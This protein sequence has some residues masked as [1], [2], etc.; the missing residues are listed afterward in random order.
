MGLGN[1]WKAICGATNEGIEAVEDT[2]SMRILD[3]DMR[4]AD[5]AISES[6]IALTKIMAQR[7]MAETKVAGVEKEVETYTNHALGAAEKGDESLAEE[8]A[9][10]VDELESTLATEKAILEGFKKSE[11]T[12]KKRIKDATA[13]IKRTKQTIAQVKATA[14]VQKAQAAVSSTNTGAGSSVNTALSSLE[15]IKKQQEEKAAQF[16]A[17]EELANEGTDAGL[18]ERL[19]KAGVSPGGQM[20]GKSKLAELMA[21]KAA[22]EAAAAE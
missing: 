19:K 6:N 17:A 15:K 12:L 22:A 11:V 7:K 16:E 20:G 14:S 13:T 4:T 21:K 5:K 18:E 10:K 9:E 1:L 3:Q 2:Q 8:C